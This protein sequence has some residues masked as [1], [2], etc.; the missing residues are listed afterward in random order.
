M[1]RRPAPRA[2]SRAA[3][4]S[5]PTFAAFR[6]PGYRA[7]WFSGFSAAFGWSV[8][9]VAIGWVTLQVSGNPLAVGATFAARLVPALLFGIPLGSLV[10][11]L[12]THKAETL[13]FLE[14]FAVPFD[15][16][17]AERDIR[18]TKVRQKIS[19]GFRTTTG[20]DRF[21]RIRG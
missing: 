2:R 14:D 4:Y 15:N 18:M 19:G 3:I 1:K 20:A 12:R 9:G 11:R 17:Q 13:A 8:S 5:G 21:C 7:L 16:N 6:V 10:D